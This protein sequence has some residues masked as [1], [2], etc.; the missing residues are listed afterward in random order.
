VAREAAGSKKQRDQLRAAM[1]DQGCTPEQIAAEM[2][3]QFGFRARQAWRHTHGWTQDEVA[4][5]YNRLL[6]HDQA[7]MAGKRISDYEAWPH[8]GVKPTIN[9]LAVL[10][11]VYST[12]VS[13]LV[14]LD[15][16]RALNA[17]ELLTIDTH[18]TAPATPGSPDTPSENSA[19]HPATA[20]ERTAQSDPA[21]SITIHQN[22]HTPEATV[23]SKHRRWH[24]VL[25]VLLA[26]ATVISA[27]IIVGKTTTS[28][29]PTMPPHTST[30]ELSPSTASISPSALPPSPLPS[31]ALTVAIPHQPL[32][33]EPTPARTARI[34][35]PQPGPLPSQIMLA[36]PPESATPPAPPPTHSDLLSSSPESPTAETAS[37]STASVS[38]KNVYYDRCL[39]EQ[40]GAITRDPAN[41]QLWDCIST[42]NQMWTEKTIA[43]NPTSIAKNLVSSR[44]GRC[45]T[46]QPGDYTDRARIWLT[47]CGKEGQGWIRIHNGGATYMFEAAEVR[48]M[49]MAATNGPIDD[50]A[51]AYTGI[52]L[53]RCDTS[54]PLKDWRF[55]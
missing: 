15:D 50:A 31:P 21:V 5:A 29:H 23:P 42:S 30:P 36:S 16:R 27:A 3:R 19:Q 48:G 32:L 47:P 10:A 4:D 14:D 45:V 24:R 20:N 38:W 25:I 49:C 33:V 35:A 37:A 22:N 28:V 7:P 6:D 39:D 17:Q 43:A 34:A 11:K 44:T 41:I 46:Y 55:Y 13:T 8:G 26:I 9:A 54:S 18:K 2:G 53:R 51:G 12:S 40:E 52:L 1:R